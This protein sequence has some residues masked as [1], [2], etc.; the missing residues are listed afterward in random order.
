[1]KMNVGY[2]THNL[3]PCRDFYVQKLGFSVQFENEWYVLLK[4]P[5]SGIE[6]SFLQPGLE[7][8]A[9]VFQTAYNGK[10]TYLTIEV[11]DVE[12]L[13]GDFKERGITIYRDLKNEEWGD[14]HFI[15][16]DPN[17]TGL[18]FVTYRPTE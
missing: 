14:H 11:P 2:V 18:D 16:L 10:G 12:A 17:G 13:Y 3:Q 8:Q 6:I 1:M 9:P 7:F 15:V 5:D 4:A